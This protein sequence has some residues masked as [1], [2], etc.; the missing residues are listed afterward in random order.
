MKKVKFFM[1]ESVYLGVS[2]LEL[3]I[4][5]MYEFGIIA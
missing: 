3:I 5:S 4:I 1:N 2:I